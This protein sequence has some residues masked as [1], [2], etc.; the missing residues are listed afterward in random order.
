MAGTTTDRE[1]ASG[2]RLKS[3]FWSQLRNHPEVGPSKTHTFLKRSGGMN[4][5]VV[6]K[7]ILHYTN[8]ERTRRGLKKLKGQ[9]SLIRAARGHSRWM[10]RRNRYSHTGGGGSQPQHRVQRAGYVSVSVGENIWRT[11]GS[12]GLAWHSRFHWNSSWRLGHA[13][14]ISWMNSPGHRE[15]ILNPS[16]QH[17][18]IGVGRKRKGE[19]YLTQNFGMVDGYVD[20]SS[21]QKALAWVGIGITIALLALAVVN[22]GW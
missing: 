2:A 1:S 8:R 19:V 20:G 5:R 3:P 6:E 18:G 17:I 14:V 21:F 22:W 16:W 15:N 4:A 10:A 9:P 12:S 13:A 7:S 11:S